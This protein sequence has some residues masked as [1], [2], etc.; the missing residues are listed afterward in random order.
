MMGIESSG[1]FV[2]SIG[3]AT[4]WALPLLVSVLVVGVGFWMLR[5]THHKVTGRWMRELYNVIGR[6]DPGPVR[7]TK[8]AKQVWSRFLEHIDEAR[9]LQVEARSMEVRSNLLGNENRSLQTVFQALPIGI[10]A[11][12]SANRI[13]YANEVAGRLLQLEDDDDPVLDAAGGA[14]CVVGAVRSI[15][16]GDLARGIRTERIEVIRDEEEPEVFRV[17]LLANTAIESELSQD[18]IQIVTFENITSEEST[19]RMKTEFVYGVSHE[20]KTPLTSIQASLEMLVEEENLDADDRKRL[21]DLSYSESIRLGRMVRELLDLARVE[22]GVTEVH[23]E[24]VVI[25]DLMEDLKAVHEPLATRKSITMHWEVSD[26]A[27]TVV[28]D[29]DL[30]LQAFVNLIGNAIK[31]TRDS[32]QVDIKANVEGEELVVK[33]SDNGIGIPAEDLPKVFDKFYRS[34]PA[35]KSSIPGTGLGLPMARFIIETHGGRIEVDSVDGEGTTFTAYLPREEA[36]SEDLDTT[37]LQSLTALT[38]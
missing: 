18:Q 21:L 10:L 28:A 33:V 17:R 37:G 14:P 38:N 2:A 30:L 8:E 6:P 20:L 34:G 13:I 23:R 11:L 25:A 4:A 31:Y 35:R 19:Q 3:G 26:F 9:R 24:R 22:A 5:K 7:N 32:G 15:L 16:S 27:P 29:R 1:I 36:G 12:R